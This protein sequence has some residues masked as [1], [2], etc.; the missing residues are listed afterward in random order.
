LPRHYLLIVRRKFFQ[1]S[2]AENGQDDRLYFA[3]VGVGVLDVRL[4]RENRSNHNVDL[5]RDVG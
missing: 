3:V 5:T 1:E 2:V 4:R